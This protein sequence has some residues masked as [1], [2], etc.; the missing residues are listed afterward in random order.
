MLHDQRIR[1]LISLK[2]SGEATPEELMELETLVKNNPELLE[3]VEDLT[4]LWKQLGR[5]STGLAEKSF[6]NHL[7]K[8]NKEI[9]EPNVLS[10]TSS[11]VQKVTP[12]RK[13]VQ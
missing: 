7:H 6:E 10:H 9:F 8:L 2:L 13:L 12:V 11:D 3:R 4:R 5:R 1:L